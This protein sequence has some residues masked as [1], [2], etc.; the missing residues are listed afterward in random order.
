[1]LGDVLRL[2]W[3]MSLGSL[4]PSSLTLRLSELSPS[5]SDGELGRL[6]SWGQR[7]EG[8]SWSGADFF[9]PCVASTRHVQTGQQ[10]WP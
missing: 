9:L 5:P 1:M 10:A 2:S 6:I 8:G 4:L 7:K 3:S